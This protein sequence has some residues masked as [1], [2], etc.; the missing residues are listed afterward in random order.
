MNHHGISS[1]ATAGDDLPCLREAH[2][3]YPC[4]SECSTQ[5][6]MPSVFD[7]VLPIAHEATKGCDVVLYTTALQMKFLNGEGQE[8][9]YE[10]PLCTI[11]FV[12]SENIR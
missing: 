5:L 11:A 6:C 3:S 9:W 7:G 2:T 1:C 8:E 4:A 10:T 12:L